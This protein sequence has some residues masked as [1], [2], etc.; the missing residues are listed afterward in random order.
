MIESCEKNLIDKIRDQIANLSI[1][2][3]RWTV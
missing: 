3:E 2:K 1:D